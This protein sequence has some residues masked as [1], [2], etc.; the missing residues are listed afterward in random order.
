MKAIVLGSGIK[1][2]PAA[3]VAKYVELQTTVRHTRIGGSTESREYKKA[4]K[5]FDKFYAENKEVL[6]KHYFTQA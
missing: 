1:L 2:S 6:D 4:V 5:A 3:V